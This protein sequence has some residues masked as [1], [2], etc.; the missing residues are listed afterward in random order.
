MEN[1]FLINL[2]IKYGLDEGTLVKVVDCVHELGYDDINS[3]D[4]QRAAI[5][6]CSMNLIEMPSE[7]LIEEMR[8]K[9]FGV[10][11]E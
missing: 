8:R 6:I 1:K 9:G 7:S 10:V 3:S 2:T 5:Y 4:F 11:E